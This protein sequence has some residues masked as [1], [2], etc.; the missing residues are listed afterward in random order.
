[1][2]TGYLVKTRNLVKVLRRT[3]I[4]KIPRV[5]CPIPLPQSQW[6]K[7]LT[8]L[9]IAYVFKQYH[10]CIFERFKMS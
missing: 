6:T 8:N 9:G 4:D 7:P 1:M 2:I 10:Q 3:V 5:K